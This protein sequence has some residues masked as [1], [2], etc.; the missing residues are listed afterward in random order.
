M[1]LILL[2]VY[3]LQSLLHHKK[4]SDWIVVTA[5]FFVGLTLLVFVARTMLRNGD[6]LSRPTIIK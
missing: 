4:S 3:G 1:G 5:K 2:C 6:W